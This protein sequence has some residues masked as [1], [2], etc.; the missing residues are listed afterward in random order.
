MTASRAT[1]Q[2]LVEFL[3]SAAR[4]G[5]LNH[6]TA[7]SLRAAV[8]QILDFDNSDLTSVNIQTLDVDD[9]LERFQRARGHKYVPTSLA[10]Y[11]ARFRRA[12]DMYLDYV[13]DPTGWR[14]PRGRASRTSSAPPKTVAQPRTGGHDGAS[15][16]RPPVASSDAQMMTYEFPLALGQTAYLQLPRQLQ[17]QDVSRL[18]LFLRGL[19]MDTGSEE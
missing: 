1:G 15:R 8:T 7:A 9:L 17:A 6:S 12:R 14:P 13:K 16:S 11:C 19:V 10:S 5:A 2:G 18:T 4:R 3:D